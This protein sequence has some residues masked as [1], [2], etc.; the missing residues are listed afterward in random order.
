MAVKV[1]AEQA[2]QFAVVVHALL[3]DEA[4][5]VAFTKAPIATLKEHGVEFKDP[6]V[7]KKVEADLGR[8]LGEIGDVD[9]C[10]PIHFAYTRTYTNP[11]TS[12]YTW[13]RTRTAVRATCITWVAKPEEIDDVIKIDQPRID[14]FVTKVGL[15]AR[16]ATLEAR[17]AQLEGNPARR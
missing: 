1:F 12:V 8:F 11:Y 14:A 15:E 4:T 9:I 3:Q 17:I 16:I 2:E 6:A 5:R 13:V 10:P 7:A